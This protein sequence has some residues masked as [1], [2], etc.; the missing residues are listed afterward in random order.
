MTDPADRVKNGGKPAS[1]EALAALQTGS[2]K[3]AKQFTDQRSSPVLSR[4]GH[5]GARWDAWHRRSFLSGSCLDKG[6]RN[7]L[8]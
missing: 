5:C 7:L 1:G 6:P 8:S 3:R 4:S 2:R